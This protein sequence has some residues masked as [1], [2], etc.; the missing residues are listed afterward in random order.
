MLADRA[1]GSSIIAALAERG[2]SLNHQNISN[3]KHGGF[4]DWL[5]EQDWRAE[6]NL[7][8]EYALDLLDSGDGTKFQQAVIQL[9]VTQIFKTLKKS[10]FNNDPSNYTRLLNSLSRLAREAVVM[11]KYA[12][13]SAREKLHELKQLDPNREISDKEHQ[14]WYGK[15]EQF[16]RLKPGTLSHAAAAAARQ[17][18]SPDHTPSPPV[19]VPSQHGNGEVA[20]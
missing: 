4:E 9:A 2:I 3:W 8:R 19:S 12:D 18:Q 1:R 16:F 5:L 7:Q 6:V 17:T 15:V 11:K 20:S 14:L 10:N 13:F